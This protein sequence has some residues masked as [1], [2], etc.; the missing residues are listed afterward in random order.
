RRNASKVSE[1]AARNGG[2]SGGTADRAEHQRSLSATASSGSRCSIGKHW[3]NTL[4]SVGEGLHCANK[5]LSRWR[6]LS[7]K[8]QFASQS[9]RGVKMNIRLTPVLTIILAAI[10]CF[11]AIASTVGIEQ[12]ISMALQSNPQVRAARARWKAAEHNVV[13]DYAPADPI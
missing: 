9:S 13:Q 4:A 2:R 3:P 11:P 5:H 12:L 10:F 8:F 7:L 6:P 1:M